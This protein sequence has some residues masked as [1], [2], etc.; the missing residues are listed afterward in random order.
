MLANSLVC[1]NK[2]R[3]KMTWGQK[4][5]KSWLG[6]R[7]IR[8]LD[9]GTESSEVLQVHMKLTSSGSLEIWIMYVP[10]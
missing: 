8:S 9:L 10:S 5:Q 2:R 4:P 6:N 7:K 3:E 1:T